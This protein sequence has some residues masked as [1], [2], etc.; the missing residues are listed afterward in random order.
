M[1]SCTA[2]C[3]I[4]LSFTI[5][6]NLLKLMSI[7]LVMP[8]NHTQLHFPGSWKN[9]QV[10]LHLWIFIFNFANPVEVSKKKKK[11]KNWLYMPL[12]TLLSSGG[13]S[14][15]NPISMPCIYTILWLLV[16]SLPINSCQKSVS[17]HP[18]FISIIPS[19]CLRRGI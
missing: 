3:Q 9:H 8:S 12:S 1:T 14:K 16:I 19:C 18:L 15:G 17:E 13:C 7:E 4:S 6:W 10:T 11:K 5:S 2:A